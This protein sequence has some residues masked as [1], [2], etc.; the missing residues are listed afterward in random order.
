MTPS[1]DISVAH[2][3][4]ALTT[5]IRLLKEQMTSNRSADKLEIAAVKASLLPIE[6]KLTTLSEARIKAGGILVGAVTAIS[7]FGGAV[8]GK[9]AQLLGLLG[10]T[11]NGNH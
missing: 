5:E 6:A 9:I 4:G 11:N 3:L 10:D 8:G 1:N 2:E 7:V